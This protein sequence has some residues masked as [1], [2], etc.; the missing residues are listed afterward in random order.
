MDGEK[1]VRHVESFDILDPPP[2]IRSQH[3]RRRMA[4]RRSVLPSRGA[5]AFRDN[6]PIPENTPY[7]S[8]SETEAETAFTEDDV[9]EN[10]EPRA[11][12]DTFPIYEN[13]DVETGYFPKRL[14]PKQTKHNKPQPPVPPHKTPG[15]RSSPFRDAHGRLPEKQK[16]RQ[17]DD[18]SSSPSDSSFE[19]VVTQPEP[20]YATVRKP[21]RQKHHRPQSQDVKADAIPQQD[22]DEDLY[23]CVSKPRW[24]A[25]RSKT[26]PGA[27]AREEDEHRCG[28]E[29][30]D[31]DEYARVRNAIFDLSSVAW[32]KNPEPAHPADDLNFLRNVVS[33]RD[34]E[35]ISRYIHPGYRVDLRRINTC[36][37]MPP[38][39]L[40]SLLDVQ[41]SPE[42][43]RTASLAKPLI[44]FIVMVNYYYGAVNKLTGM[45]CSM[46]DLMQ[47]QRVQAIRSRLEDMS[48]AFGGLSFIVRIFGRNNVSKEQLERSLECL[49]TLIANATEETETTDCT[50]QLKLMRKLNPL[51]HT[52]R[53]TSPSAIKTYMKNLE[54]LNLGGGHA[55]N[56]VCTEQTSI[57]ECLLLSDAAFVV[58]LGHMIWEF[59]RTLTLLK[60]LLMFQM[61]ELSETIYLAY[62]QMPHAQKDYERLMK[63]INAQLEAADHNN[64]SLRAVVCHM[65][66]FLRLAHESGLF[67]SP[68]YT[69]H[70]ISQVINHQSTSETSRISVD[71]AADILTEPEIFHPSISQEAAKK[72]FTRS[73]IIARLNGS[74]TCDRTTPMIHAQIDDLRPLITRMVQRSAAALAERPEDFTR[75]GAEPLEIRNLTSVIQ[76]IFKP[77]T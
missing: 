56:L 71:A 76:S 69:K 72:I 38:Y 24:E 52:A 53:F 3:H 22:T 12:R 8:R 20:L 51:F 41:I 62:F 63:E 32:S 47:R 1:P 10:V 28:S 68:T 70:A 57:S 77:R 74:P 59:G 48:R 37:P 65:I 11:Y 46:N 7:A 34:A 30:Q 36:I 18:F 26:R 6:Y 61:H 73:L 44:K 13:V 45:K 9:Y 60:S 4:S 5:G 23:S 66:N 39:V 58:C 14:P 67:I 17:L 49:N 64:Y 21:P 42:Y 55:L 29:S 16:Y 35:M 75:Q 50:E 31:D 43:V 19:V 27:A 54:I 33:Q 40:E 25:P 15:R 2:S